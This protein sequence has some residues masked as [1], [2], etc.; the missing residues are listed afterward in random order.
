MIIAYRLTMKDS[1]ATNLFRIRSI[2]ILLILV[3]TR[4]NLVSGEG[5]HLT[6][7]VS[8]RKHP[9]MKPILIA[10]HQRSSLVNPGT[11]I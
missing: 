11:G 10:A 8:L 5:T 2:L 4:L 9:E 6:L 3:L 1:A 7:T